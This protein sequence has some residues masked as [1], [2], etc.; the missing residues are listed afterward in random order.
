VT[1]LALPAPPLPATVDLR[2]YEYM[3]LHV[4]RLRDSETAFKTKGD[5]FRCAV[6]L[7]C[8]AWHQVPASSLPDDEGSLAKYA[9]FGI[10]VKEWRK[11]REGALRGF[12]KCAD[13]RLYHTV[14]AKVA[15]SSWISKLKQR[16]RS[17]CERLKKQA[18]RT[19]AHF[20]RPDFDLWISRECPE[21]L[22]FVSP[23]QMDAVPEDADAMSP[24][25]GGPVPGETGSNRSEVKGIIP[26]VTNVET[27]D[28]SART[29]SHGHP[30]RE[31][32]T[33]NP[34]AHVRL[35]HRWKH[36]PGECDKAM[37]LL[38]IQSPKGGTMGECIRLVEQELARRER[39][40][41]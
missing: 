24:G 23:G 7:W 35:P 39:E 32:G 40:A 2:D 38:G 26:V 3:P 15:V 19:K 16:Y 25:Q 6:L 13:G 21:A 22:P 17:D 5:E 27:R 28:S 34:R 18:Q 12:V 8:A 30:P 36:D 10:A 20:V 33:S 14:L 37:K 9:G 41:A 4:V 29:S 11:V 31:R 1:A